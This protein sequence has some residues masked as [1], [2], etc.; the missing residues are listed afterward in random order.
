MGTAIMPNSAAAALLSLQMM[1]STSMV[2]DL[3]SRVLSESLDRP[4]SAGPEDRAIDG[5]E[6]VY[7]CDVPVD[8]LAQCF[9]HLDSFQDMAS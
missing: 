3:K 6:K 4:S 9:L 7:V 8:V 2:Q 1:G 5:S